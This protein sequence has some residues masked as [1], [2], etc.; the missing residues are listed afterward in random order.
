MSDENDFKILIGAELDSN[1]KQNLQGDLNKI[2]DLSAT[3]E[4]L[5]LSPEATQSLKNA[6][7]NNGIDID[8]NINVGGNGNG[9]GITTQQRQQAQKTGQQIGQII[10]DNAEK[11]ISDVTSKV[12]GEGFKVSPKMSR[13][14]ETELK[15]MV[16][17]W[18]NGKGK[19]SSIVVETTTDFNE[20]ELK[21]V[22]QLKSATI[23]YSNALGEVITKKLRYRQTGLSQSASGETEVIKGWVESSSAY[24]KSLDNIDKSTTAFMNRQKKSVV[25]LTNQVKQI[26]QS[27]TDPNVAKPIKDSNNLNNL[28][29]QYNDIISAI[30]KMGTASETTF[31][32]ERNNVSTLISDLK[33]LVRQY[34][35]AET[36]ATTMRSRDI[37]TI[38]AVKGN[39]LDEFIAKI[40][41]SKVPISQ[42]QTEIDTL[43]TALSNIGDTDSLTKF[44]NQFDVTNSKFKALKEQFRQQYSEQTQ[45]D[46]KYNAIKQ[47]EKERLAIQ[48]QLVGTTGA[49]RTALERQYNKRVKSIQRNQD[50]LNKHNLTDNDMTRE[51]SNITASG[52]E[53]VNTEIA[54]EI[55]SILAA[56]IKVEQEWDKQGISVEELTEKSKELKNILNGID[57]GSTLDISDKIKTLDQ[58]RN[59]LNELKNT[60]ND[61]IASQGKADTTLKQ[62]S[63]AYKEILTIQN[64]ITKLDPEQNKA[65]IAELQTKKTKQEEI[66]KTCQETYDVMVKECSTM[67]E[68]NALAQ[69]KSELMTETYNAVSQAE[70]TQ[71]EK[72]TN[73]Q[74]SSQQTQQDKES[75]KIAN[76]LETI[77]AKVI[78]GDYSTQIKQ[79]EEALKRYGMTAEQVEQEVKELTEA[80][81]IMSSA[82]ATPE[83]KIATEQRYQTALAKTKNVV[84]EASLEW[85][86]LATEQQRLSLA[87]SIEAF[88]QKNTRITKEA[89]ETLTQYIVELRDLDTAMTKVRKNDISVAFKKTENS[90]R[91]LHKLGYALTDQFKQAAG[92]FTQWLSVSSLIMT[93]VGKTR[94]SI[95]EL[96]EIDNILTEI[97]KTSDMTEKELAQLGSTSFATA[98]AMGRTATDYLNT[99]TEM[100][101]SGFYG[102]QGEAMAQQ[103]LLAQ[104]AGDLT[105]DLAN[106]YIL[107]TNAA[108]KLNGSAKELNG[109][110]DGQ[111]MVTNR[112]SVAMEDMAEAMSEAGSVAAAYRVEA[113]EFTAMVGT[114]EAVT[115]LGGSEI[116]NGLKSL[117]INLQN[118][119][120]SKI[121]GTLDKASA[122]MTTIVDGAEKL[123]KPT[124]ILRDLSKTFKTLDEDDP[125]RAEI[126][127]NVGGKYQAEYCLYVQKCA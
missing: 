17:K 61:K 16:S 93:V 122:S 8:L 57:L 96:I 58:A 100:S 21:N 31:A 23:Q 110:L 90:M 42:M 45:Q 64:K 104:T 124:E 29:I 79:Q 108:Y 83:Q 15:S 101:R 85:R 123:R 76:K 127:T 118:V 26:Y 86:N 14:V 53:K 125:L 107:A 9:N 88:M 41:N 52:S 27:A 82:D 62:M 39:E 72:E 32:D 91:A 65:E 66:L 5:N 121:T 74:Q 33:I 40:K 43:N 102:E 78:S 34:K 36:A 80:L 24:K 12:I 73:K 98:S 19:V 35:N 10:S 55:N 48:A 106:Q 67:E 92:S 56:L 105:A 20:Q 126:L 81:Q 119:S 47:A 28:E 22:E 111:N 112:N 25:D 68:Q 120:S 18:T 30:S 11:A 75:Q 2:K 7:K 49:E 70:R 115:K 69:K 4:K 50:Y 109:I 77:N 51:V 97:S 94:Q 116:G 117:L 60:T 103:A 87:N 3:I 46:K 99:V 71:R 1:A 95:T 63:N 37:T 89:R 44:L 84:K 13:Q 38:K 6:L 113:D 59:T 54:K 114:M